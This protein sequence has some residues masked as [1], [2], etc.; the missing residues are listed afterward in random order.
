MPNR[1]PHP[2]LT[3]PF[4]S[5]R[6]VYTARRAAPCRAAPRRDTTRLH[7]MHSMHC[8]CCTHCMFCMYHMC[9]MYCVYHMH[10]TYPMCCM[11]G[12]HCMY[13]AAAWYDGTGADA[14]ERD[15]A[16]CC[17]VA[18]CTIN[19]TSLESAKHATSA[20]I[21]IYIYT[22]RERDVCVY[23]YIY[24]CLFMYICA[25]S[26][27]AYRLAFV[28][29]IGP[30]YGPDFAR[31]CAYIYIYMHI[32]VY[33]HTHYI[34]TTH[35]YIYIHIYTYTYIVSFPSELCSRRSGMVTEVACLLP[36]DVTHYMSYLWLLFVLYS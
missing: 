26:A 2:S 7:A 35:I 27:P 18:S 28:H 9:C 21:C 32:H 19:Y 33:I 23:I 10:H 11:S 14:C 31:P 29:V 13:R 16:Y 22:Y 36:P 1:L 30:A 24:I 12:V 6:A 3:P 8:M 25:T 4:V 15:A 20:C 17:L 34:Y 5:S